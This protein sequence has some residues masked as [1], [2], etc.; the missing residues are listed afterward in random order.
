M[1]LFELFIDNL[2]Y[3]QINNNDIKFYD[4]VFNFI[5]KLI[6]PNPYERL[7]P[8]EAYKEYKGIIK[9]FDLK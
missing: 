2:E 5:L 6:N 8:K 1:S 7:Y 9:K 4:D 3:H